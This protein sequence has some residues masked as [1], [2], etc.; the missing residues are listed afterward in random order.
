MSAHARLKKRLEQMQ[1][2]RTAEER[3]LAQRT[4]LLGLLTPVYREGRVAA[5]HYAPRKRLEGEAFVSL[6]IYALAAHLRSD[7]PRVLA[8]AG[9]SQAEASALCAQATVTAQ[10]VQATAQSTTQ[11]VCALFEQLWPKRGGALFQSV[12]R[13]VDLDVF[14]PPTPEQQSEMSCV[15]TGLRKRKQLAVVALHW[16]PGQGEEQ[17]G[18]SVYYSLERRLLPVVGAIAAVSGFHRRVFAE[19]KPWIERETAGLDCEHLP[20]TLKHLKERADEFTT[21]KIKDELRWFE[22]ARGFLEHIIHELA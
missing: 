9:E 1:D 12:S 6:L 13:C 19:L 20:L 11:T 2:A 5:A 14:A 16:P 7:A 17:K 4:K 8:A 10:W 15:L 3:R 18:H 21:D 22:H